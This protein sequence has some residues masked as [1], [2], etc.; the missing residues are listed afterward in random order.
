MKCPHC[1]KEIYVKAKWDSIG[2]DVEGDWGIEKYL[3][4]NPKCGKWIFYLVMGKARLTRGEF[5]G[6]EPV[7]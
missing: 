7:R 1:R 2:K 5:M 4:P 3:C 6:I